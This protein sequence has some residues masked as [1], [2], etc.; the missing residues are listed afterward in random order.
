MRPDIL[1]YT[2]LPCT[3]VSKARQWRIRVLHPCLRLAKKCSGGMPWSPLD[4][5]IVHRSLSPEIP[6]DRR[7]VC[8]ATS[9]FLMLTSPITTCPMTS[10]RFGW[11]PRTLHSLLRKKLPPLK[12]RIPNRGR[13]GR[14][15]ADSNRNRKEASGVSFAFPRARVSEFEAS[16]TDFLSLEV[17]AMHC[18]SA[19]LFVAGRHYVVSDHRERP[20]RHW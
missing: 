14:G 2:D 13:L 20:R 6:G 12:Q 16:R 7:G 15:S 11:W 10:G 9:R 3:R 1:L 18:C 8:K 4:T 5:T 17:P 19:G